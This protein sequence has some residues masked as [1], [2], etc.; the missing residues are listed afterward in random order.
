MGVSIAFFSFAFIA[1]I[2]ALLVVFLKNVFRSAL[3]LVLCFFSV[4]GIFITLGADFIAGVQVLLYVGAIGVMLLMAIMFTRGVERGNIPTR[5]HLWAL[6]LGFIFLISLI[7]VILN[8]PWK[9]VSPPPPQPTTFGLGAV[10][11]DLEKG[12]V[13]PF[14]IASLLLLSAIIGAIVLMRT[15]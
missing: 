7:W 12:F 4:A 2:S 5:W 14:E 8:T 1:I 11:F 6:F 13:L 3:F 9:V 15:K 10:L